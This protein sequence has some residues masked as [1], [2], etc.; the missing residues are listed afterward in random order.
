MIYTVGCSFTYGDELSD[1]KKAWPFLLAN[2]LQTNVLNDAVSGG[3]NYRT[4]YH[5]T[6]HLQ[7][8]FDLY[9][10]A[11]TST[12]RYTFYKSDNNYEINFNPTLRN[13]LYQDLK[14]YSGWG[15]RPL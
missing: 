1:N 13:D 9:I 14:F 3:S 4:V 8:N 10:I 5:T 12:A 6:K 11:W 15:G 7:D 2:K